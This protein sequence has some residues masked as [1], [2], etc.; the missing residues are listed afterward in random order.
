MEVVLEKDLERV[1]SD[2]V[3]EPIVFQ[4][5]AAI[6]LL[7]HGE[8]ADELDETDEQ[9]MGGTQDPPLTPR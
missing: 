9:Y 5:P 1:A 6:Y 4:P 7:R 2:H 3:M 8:R